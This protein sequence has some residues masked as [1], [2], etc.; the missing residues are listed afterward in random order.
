MYMTDAPQ[1]NTAT[2]LVAN[3]ICEEGLKTWLTNL[4][5]EQ[6]YNGEAA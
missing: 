4:I 1:A 2:S 6:T 5:F 3:C